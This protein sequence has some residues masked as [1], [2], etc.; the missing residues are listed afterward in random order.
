MFQ[1]VF[2]AY[3]RTDATVEILVMLVVAFILGYL[4]RFFIGQKYKRQA[5]ELE[6]RLLETEGAMDKLEAENDRLQEEVDQASTPPQANA[7]GESATQAAEHAATPLMSTPKDDLT[8]VEGIG[9]KIQQ[10]LN[11]DGIYTFE[12]L[13]KVEVKRL[14]NILQAAGPRFRMH[15]PA[16]W[17]EQA[18]MAAKGEWTKLV[19]WQDKLKGGRE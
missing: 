5:K 8:K 18:D 10:L 16:T 11:D 19:H 15:E 6:A 13:A 1:N 3:D 12:E 14:R 4:L 2:L 7:S 17:P 9:P